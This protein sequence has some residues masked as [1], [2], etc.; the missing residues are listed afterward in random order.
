MATGHGRIGSF[1]VFDV[2]TNQKHRNGRSMI[3][4]ACVAFPNSLFSNQLCSRD[5]VIQLDSLSF[6]CKLDRE[7]YNNYV[8]REVRDLTGKSGC[9]SIAYSIEGI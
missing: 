2:E 9:P 5:Q 4:F 8:S 6:L 1:A 7:D 3:E